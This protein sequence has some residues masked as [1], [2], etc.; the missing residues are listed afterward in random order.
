M[1][2]W[3]YLLTLEQRFYTNILHT[4]H[5]NL[6][7]IIKINKFTQSRFCVLTEFSE[8]DGFNYLWNSYKREFW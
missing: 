6:I 5:Y 8:I 4:S 2:K 3:K 1:S 7:A